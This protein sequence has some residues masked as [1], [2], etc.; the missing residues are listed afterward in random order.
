MFLAL[1]CIA[2]RWNFQNGSSS[3]AWSA[4][5]RVWSKT[6]APTN[7]INKH[8]SF[9]YVSNFRFLSEK[10]MHYLFIFPFQILKFDL[11]I[12]VSALLVW[13]QSKG[14]IYAYY[15]LRTISKILSQGSIFFI[16]VAYA[17]RI[18]FYRNYYCNFL[19]A[20]FNGVLIFRLFDKENNNVNL[21]I[22]RQLR[23]FTHP[24]QVR[25]YPVPHFLY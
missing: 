10:R 3:T 11:C 12:F 18:I 4:C 21:R 14:Y 13:D 16:S 9:W 20:L 17:V 8:I 1:F 15:V 24:L 19:S 2:D 7:S 25:G 23:C 6:F 5:G 22:P